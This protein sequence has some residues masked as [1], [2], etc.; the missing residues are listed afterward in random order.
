MGPKS[1]TVAVQRAKGASWRATCTED[2]GGNMSPSELASSK[3][4]KPGVGG[5][6]MPSSSRQG[7]DTTKV[8]RRGAGDGNQ[9]K[10]GRGR[11]G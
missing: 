7:L 10:A 9:R 6:G 4:K 11:R 1:P 5:M 8:P 2:E 3:V